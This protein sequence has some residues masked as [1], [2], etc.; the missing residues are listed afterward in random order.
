MIDQQLITSWLVLF[1]LVSFRCD[2][3]L[4]FR[5]LKTIATLESDISISSL[6]PSVSGLSKFRRVLLYV[7]MAGCVFS[8]F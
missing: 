2:F 1:S 3:F 5:H 8:Q 4:I 6:T 7:K